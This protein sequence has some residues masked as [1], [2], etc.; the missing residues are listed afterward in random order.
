V[1]EIDVLLK[2]YEDYLRG[3]WK[4]NL[5]GPQKVWFALYDPAQERRLRFRI[6][7]LE[8]ATTK[9]GHSWEHLD[10]TD[11]FARWMAQHDYREEYFQ[12]PEALDLELPDF[13]K[14][15]AAEVT[16]VLTAPHVDANTVVALSGI[17]SLFGLMRVSVLIEA[18]ASSI[19]GRLLV[20]FPGHHE[21]SIYR[22]L[23]ARDGYNYLAVAITAAK[24]D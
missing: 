5:A 13:V 19:Q 9:S 14:S 23:D 6:P 11:A 18:V 1:S 12:D 8:V 3:Q 24:G 10:L 16:A 20:F 21:G 17:A 7:E 15:L 22:L 2:A 4:P